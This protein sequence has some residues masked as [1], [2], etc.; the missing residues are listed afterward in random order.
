MYRMDKNQ[1]LLVV[2]LMKK[3]LEKVINEMRRGQVV[4]AGSKY[5]AISYKSRA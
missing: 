5:K 1:N 3:L 4:F 2:N